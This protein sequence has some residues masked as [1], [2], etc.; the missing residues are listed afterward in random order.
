[1]HAGLC[2]LAVRTV[3]VGIDFSGVKHRK[4]DDFSG[5]LW[6]NTDSES[7]LFVRSVQMFK[8]KAERIC[9]ATETTKLKD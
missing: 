2:L 5:V 3:M 7:L 8:S 6:F 4:T 9:I 1:M